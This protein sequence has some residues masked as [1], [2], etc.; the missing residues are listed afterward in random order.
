MSA[1]GREYSWV[2]VA[3]RP[4]ENDVDNMPA[5]EGNALKIKR[6]AR[7]GVARVPSVVLALLL[8]QLC[9]APAQAQSEPA[10][11]AQ[12]AAKSPSSL[13][14]R[15]K[16][17]A[18]MNAGKFADAYPLLTEAQTDFPDDM[19]IRFL[20]GQC[21]LELNK[22]AEAAAQFEAMLAVNAN[23]PRVRLELARAYTAMKN[24][25][26]AKEQF[27]LVMA[28]NPPPV[29]G[30]NVQKFL[31][32]IE[33]QRP[34]HVRVSLSYLSDSNV[35]TGPGSPSVLTGTPTSQTVTGRSDNAWNLV[36]SLSHVYV[37]DN[38]FAW[39][40]EASLNYLDYAEENSSDLA[41]FSLSTGP[42]WR[43]DK[44]TVSAPLIYDNIRVGHDPYNKSIGLAPQLQYAL[45][46]KTQL[47]GG[48]TVA[49]RD[50]D[51]A[52]ATDRNGQVYGV[53][54]GARIRLDEAGQLMPSVRLGHESTRQDYF[55]NDS[56]GVSLGYLTS[57]PHGYTLFVQPTVSR[58]AYGAADPFLAGICSGCNSARRDWLYQFTIN[59]SRP[60]GKSGLSAA[61]GYTFTRN[62]SNVGLNDYSRNQVTAMLTWIY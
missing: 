46:D 45:D 43:L 52:N 23:L 59:L 9:W 44:Y 50:H 38:R 25:G 49:W 16:A 18:L 54:G 30:D 53:T 3:P 34:W 5:Q 33:A 39:Q 28:T 62:D 51:K 17:V 31:D 12:V 55:D 1:K 13:G 60:F 22:P 2:G 40:S 37:V 7:A 57:L 26:Q 14:V 48:F 24:F 19:D 42:T 47:N 11:R 4:P 15:K 35:N 20:I 41:M 21:A 36:G 10:K 6:I 29:V 58:V 8:A 56:V 61:L 27:N 32:M